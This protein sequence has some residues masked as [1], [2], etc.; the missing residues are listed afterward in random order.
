[1]ARPWTH[2]IRFIAKEDGR[3]HLGQIN[4]EKFPDVGLAVFEGK[5]VDAKVISGSVYDGVVTD[6]T[7]HV[8]QLLPPVTVEQTPLI[9]C[10]G[11]NYRDHA[12]EANM[13]IPDV[14]VLFIKP[15]TSL[16]G[17]YPAKIN[18]PKIA[19]DDTADYEA[20]LTFILSKD[21]RDIPESDAMDYVLGYTCGNDVSAR[22]QQ[23]KNSQWN[24]GKGMDGSAPIGPVLVSPKAIPNPHGLN[25][26]ATHN[27][28]TVQETNTREMI[29]NIPKTLAY[30]SSGTTLERGTIVMTG[31]GP[32][33]GMTRNPK[34]VLR[35]GDDMRVWIESIGTLVN[36]VYYE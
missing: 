18:I 27:A 26:V 30:L 7:L 11:L 32:G 10:L 20:E 2:L 22:T 16:N 6:R 25:I 33:I 36:E 8:A 31:T 3:I 23:L 9:R 4:P 28:N 34:V 1:M 12:K 24:F 29:F 14:P 13:P 17:P 35:H 5:S 15:R 19:Q 21:G